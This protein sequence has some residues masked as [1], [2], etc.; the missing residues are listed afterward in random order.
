MNQTF[1]TQL[2]FLDFLLIQPSPLLKPFIRHYWHFQSRS[3]LPSYREVYMNPRGGYGIVFNF[4]DVVQLG[5]QTI[6]DPVFLDGTNTISRAMRFF[7]RVDML[8]IRFHEGRAFPFLGIP[9]VELRNEINLLDALNRHNLL[10]LHAQIH[11]TA[12]LS[13][14]ICL[15]D[16]WLLS[17][18]KADKHQNALVPA[19]LHLLQKSNGRFSIPELAREFAISQRQMERIYL[20]QVGMSPKQYAKLLRVDTTRFFLKQ[21]NGKSV[22][23]I[24]AELGYYDQSHLIR[25]FISVIGI[26]PHT[27]LKRTGKQME[28][29]SS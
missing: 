19:S 17:R 14:R 23:E 13:D 18:L 8:G 4:G 29:S 20:T 24:A 25:E 10:S 1:E 16:D 22:A 9:L 3:P 11:E 12:A 6:S 2:A 21:T 28:K 7:G 26:S 15:L 5:E 27:Y